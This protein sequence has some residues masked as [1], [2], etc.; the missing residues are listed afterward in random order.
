MAK[1]QQT[2]Q[3]FFE[4]VK[5]ISKGTGF[6][7][8]FNHSNFLIIYWKNRVSSDTKSFTEFNFREDEEKIE[9]ICLLITP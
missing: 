6:L 8:Y 3:F 4:I 7:I 2:L 9:F 5:I 1:K